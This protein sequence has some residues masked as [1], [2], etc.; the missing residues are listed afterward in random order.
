MRGCSEL[1][2]FYEFASAAGGVRRTAVRNPKAP[3]L[4]AF[5]AALDQESKHE[6]EENA[7][8]NSDHFSVIHTELLSIVS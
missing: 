7:S 5:A 1:L 3:L 2:E 6:N 8:N 4:D